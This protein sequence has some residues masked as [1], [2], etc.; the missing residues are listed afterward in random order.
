MIIC[1][2]GSRAPLSTYSSKHVIN[3]C[4]RLSWITVYLGKDDNETTKYGDIRI[5]KSVRVG[6]KGDKTGQRNLGDDTNISKICLTSLL[7]TKCC[8]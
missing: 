6:I 1:L 4:H 7:H 5:L 8:F 3:I 2:I